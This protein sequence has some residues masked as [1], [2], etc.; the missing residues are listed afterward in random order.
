V[1]DLELDQTF[2]WRGRRIAWAT[3]GSGPDVVFCHGTPFSSLLWHPFADALSRDFTVHVWDM[4]GYGRSSKRPDHPVDFSVQAAAFAALL[5]HWGLAAPHVVA[6]DFG[7]VVAM[8]AHLHEGARFAS[9]M[10]VDVVALPPTGSPFFRFVKANPNLLDQLPG[11]I[12]EAAVRAYVASASARGLRD[13]VLSALVAPWTGEEGQPGFYRQIVDYDERFL[14]ENESRVGDIAVPVH[15]V[16]GE[17][18]SWIPLDYAH[19]L[20]DLIPGSTLRVV[21]GAGHLI[22]YDQ[23]VALMH[24]LRSWLDARP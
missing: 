24:E 8:R 15:I 16:W 2:E 20:H 7:G 9:M 10:L 19:R 12:H 6:H 21:P 18:D 3:R 13:D 11:Y 17:E 4:P 14:D 1:P 22:H 23:P 5:D